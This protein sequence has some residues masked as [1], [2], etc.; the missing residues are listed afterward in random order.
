MPGLIRVDTQ[1][2]VDSTGN[3]VDFKKNNLASNEALKTIVDYAEKVLNSTAAKI[4]DGCIDVKPAKLS[5]TDDACKYC[6][7]SA[8][9]DFD[10]SV[11][12]TTPPVKDN[13]DTILVKMR[14]ELQR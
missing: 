8:L 13:R 12:E 9:C 6:V 14:N 7:F 5:A 10:R 1:K 3:F 11:N 2:A 4:L